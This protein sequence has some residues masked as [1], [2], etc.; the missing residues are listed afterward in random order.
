MKMDVNDSPLMTAA[1][2]APSPSEVT[3]STP[4]TNSIMQM[5]QVQPEDETVTVMAPVATPPN[6]PPPAASVAAASAAAAAKKRKQTADIC[7]QADKEHASKLACLQFEQQMRKLGT[8][9]SQPFARLGGQI[10]RHLV[11]QA[12]ENE[13]RKRHIID[14]IETTERDHGEIIITVGRTLE[15]G[16]I[17]IIIIMWVY[18]NYLSFGGG[19]GCGCGTCLESGSVAAVAR[20]WDRQHV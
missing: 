4:S 15:G 20:L 1:G 13:E 18:G 14:I 7:K 8:S 11:A 3:P 2:F 12:D 6:D 10:L 16:C 17:T 5:S 19:V 9:V